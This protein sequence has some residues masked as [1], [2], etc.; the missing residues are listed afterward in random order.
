MDLL[1]WPFTEKPTGASQ[2]TQTIVHML[3][4]NLKKMILIS[5]QDDFVLTKRINF[6]GINITDNS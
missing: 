1:R 2:H 3:L 6:K 4:L 5:E